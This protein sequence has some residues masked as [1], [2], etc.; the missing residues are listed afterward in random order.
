M[1]SNKPRGAFA[2]KCPQGTEPAN[3][4]YET[5]DGH[6]LPYGI[7]PA[8]AWPAYWRRSIPQG[9]FVDDLVPEGGDQYY[10]IDKNR[11]EHFLLPALVRQVKRF[12][13]AIRWVRTKRLKASGRPH[14]PLVPVFVG[15]VNDE[16]VCIAAPGRSR[17]MEHPR[18]AIEAALEE[19]ERAEKAAGR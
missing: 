14:V 7:I 1:G 13:P 15:L 4:T 9:G 17:V 5:D 6:E 19:V 10:C 16:V 3:C 18:D 8:D 11:R 12:Y 2:L